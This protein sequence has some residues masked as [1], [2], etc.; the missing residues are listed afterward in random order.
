[1][2]ASHRHQPP[3]PHSLCTMRY[4]HM[5]G[6]CRRVG[7]AAG[8]SVSVC[9]I[10]MRSELRPPL[11]AAAP[12]CV[13]SWKS[14]GYSIPRGAQLG[15]ELTVSTLRA[16]ACGCPAREAWDGSSGLSG[17]RE[18]G[19]LGAVR[20]SGGTAPMICNRVSS[21][22]ANLSTLPHCAV[23]DYTGG[24]SAQCARTSACPFAPG[25]FLGSG[26]A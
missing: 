4:I 12:N 25:L 19:L 9:N 11:P 2:V 23:A 3:M 24:Y 13:N 21:A 17:G 10:P 15:S 18:P 20:S 22:L 6:C 16:V 26:R 7:T 1:M 5:P 8:R 14:Q